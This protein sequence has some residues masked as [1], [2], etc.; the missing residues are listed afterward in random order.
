MTS[1]PFPLL[2]F[3]IPVRCSARSG[4][5]H[6][7]HA[8]NQYDCSWSQSKSLLHNWSDP[9]SSM[10]RFS[11]VEA[12]VFHTVEKCS[13]RRKRQQFPNQ[14]C[15]S[16][17][18]TLF[19]LTGTSSNS[20]V[21]FVNEITQFGPKSRSCDISYTLTQSLK[22]MGIK[23][24]DI[25]HILKYWA[26]EASLP[27][28]SGTAATRS[29]RKDDNMAQQDERCAAGT[30]WLRQPVCGLVSGDED[31]G[32]WSEWTVVG[33]RSVTAGFPVWLLLPLPL[34]FIT[35]QYEF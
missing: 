34:T 7:V 33:L 18:S 27:G 8:S 32:L 21:G 31:M 13:R 25:R 29:C 24:S 20:A 17:L 23:I 3:R 16:E 2:C 1:A 9:L 14:P 22:E 6:C 11:F 15:R 10:L 19:L 5:V 28:I 35:L 26:P 30:R 12:A 4:L